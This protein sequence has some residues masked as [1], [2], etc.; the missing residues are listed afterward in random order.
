MIYSGLVSVTFR[1]LSVD[2]IIELVKQ[3]Q[4]SAIEWGGDVHVPHGD[5]KCA[6]ETRLKTVD[7]GL[8]IASYGSY[9]RVGHNEPVPYE[10]VLETAVALGA[11][12]VRVWAGKHNA[13]DADAVYW[14]QVVKDSQYI[15]ELTAAAGLKV[16][17]EYHT[18]TLTNSLDSTLKL[19][20]AVGNEALTSYWQSP[21]SCSVEE[22]LHALDLLQPWLSNIHVN[23]GRQPL[24]YNDAWP[25]YLHKAAQTGRDHYA[26]IEFVMDESSEQFL[27]D[28]KTLKTWLQASY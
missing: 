20:N 15:A 25:R 7:A 18:N 17:Y 19:L 4:L 6:I 2:K 8:S 26:L 21:A 11:P 1:Q 3:A 28:A 14:E 13:E 27:Q 9:Y 23:T 12:L 16:A 22:N 5:M 24:K 10:K